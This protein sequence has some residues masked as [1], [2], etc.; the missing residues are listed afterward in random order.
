MIEIML[1]IIGYIAAVMQIVT[2]ISAALITS[3]I[4]FHN[5]RNDEVSFVKDSWD[6]Q[7]QINYL[8]VA[9]PQIAKAS[10][11]ISTGYRHNDLDEEMIRTAMFLLFIQM[12]RLNSIW[13]AMNNGIIAK[14]KALLEIKATIKILYGEPRLFH[15]CLTNRYSRDFVEFMESNAKDIIKIIPEHRNFIVKEILENDAV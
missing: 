7:Q 6:A 11:L 10:D 9:N 4:F 12:N 13:N 1:I 5:K 14:K 2:G 15:Y 8:V 3:I